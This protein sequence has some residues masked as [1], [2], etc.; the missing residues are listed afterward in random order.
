MMMAG[1]RQRERARRLLEG[2]PAAQ[3]ER[4]RDLLDNLRPAPFLAQ[5]H[6]P[7]DPRPILERYRLR[8][9]ERIVEHYVDRLLPSRLSE[10]KTAMLVSMLSPPDRPY[11]A[12]APGAPR[13]VRDLVVLIMSMPEYQMN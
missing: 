11:D 10:D 1:P 7:Y 12:D 2:L 4:V 13:R 5:T 9:P 6:R 8:T 3:A